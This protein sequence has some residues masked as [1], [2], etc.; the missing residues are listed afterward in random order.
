MKPTCERCGEETK[1]AGKVTKLCPSCAHHF[2][3]KRQAKKLRAAN[4]ESRRRFRESAAGRRQE[5]ARRSTG[6]RPEPSMPK[7][8]CL[9]GLE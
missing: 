1:G 8:K 4:A 3:G 5:S 6:H 7:F 2:V 9:E